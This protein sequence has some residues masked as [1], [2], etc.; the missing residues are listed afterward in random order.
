MSNVRSQ[1]ACH[2]HTAEGA[3]APRERGAERSPRLMRRKRETRMRLLHAAFGLVSKK[4]MDSVTINEITDAADV[5]FG[6]FYNHFDSKEG[7]FTALIEWLFEEFADTLDGLVSGLADPAEVLAVSVRHTLLR[8]CRDPVWGQLLIREGLSA[9]AL[10]TGLGQRL[11]RDMRRGIA[12]SRFMVADELLCAI[13]AIGTV[14]AGLAAE[15]RSPSS[16]QRTS[17]SRQ[18]LHSREER[19]AENIAT[20]VLQGVGLKRMEA[21]RIARRPMPPGTA[22]VS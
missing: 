14:L 12:Q 19:F 10:S 22:S 15:L 8:A 2:R 3:D 17:Q 11:L 21:E 9:H 13:S 7:L 5:G 4:G 20:V 18:A 1:R 6:S 16:S